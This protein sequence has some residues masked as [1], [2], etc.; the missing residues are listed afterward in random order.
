MTW[1]CLFA[2]CCHAFSS[3]Q[4]CKGTPPNYYL[5]LLFFSL[6]DHLATFNYVGTLG[7]WKSSH[8]TSLSFLFKYSLRGHAL[9][10]GRDSGS[11]L[12]PEHHINKQTKKLYQKKRVIEHFSSHLIFRGNGR[13][14]VWGLPQ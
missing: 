3:I 8:L 5:L 9:L 2:F 13:G 6:L 11:E 7:W 14:G 12:I 1:C 4:K 10:S